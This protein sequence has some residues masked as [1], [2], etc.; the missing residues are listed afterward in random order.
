MT[1]GYQQE[2]K[3]W[4]SMALW[5]RDVAMGPCIFSPS[6]GSSRI[7][8]EAVTLGLMSS[9]ASVCHKDLYIVYFFFF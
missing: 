2:K 7:G 1:Y 8:S 6:K 9:K 5:F 4:H 3:H